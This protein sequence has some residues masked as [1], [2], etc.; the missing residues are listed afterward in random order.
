MNPLRKLAS[1]T[2]IYGFSSVVGRFL[3]YLLVPLFTYYFAPEEYGVIAELYAYMGFLTVTL[4]LGLETGYFRFSSDNKWDTKIVYSTTLRTIIG[5]N[6]LFLFLVFIFLT[7]LATNLRYQQ[8][9]QFLAWTAV[10]LAADSVGAIA[11]A[12][13]RAEHQ[14]MRFAGIKLLEIAVNIGFNLFFI[15]YCKAKYTADPTSWAGSLWYPEV[16]VGYVLIANLIA[17]IA[18][19][20]LL[21]TE[22]KG[23]T[24]GFNISLLNRIL[25]Y[26]LPMVIIGFAGIINEMLDRVVL[27][28]LLPYDSTQNMAQLGIYSAC[29]KLSILMSLFIQ[30]FRYAGE[31][32]FFAYAQQANAKQIY[33]AVLRY[34]VIA[35]VFIFLVVSLYID[36]F[37]YFVGAPYRVGIQVTPILLFANLFLGIYVNLSIWYKLS[38]HTLIGAAVSILGAVITLVLLLW[39]VPIFGYIGAAWATLVCY[40]TMAVISYILGNYYY[41]VP[42]D[43][44]RIITYLILGISIYCIHIIVINHTDI[45]SILV[46]TIEIVAF[47][48][49]A[50]W[51]DGRKLKIA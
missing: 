24:N 38:D 45:S 7:P 3:N 14:A 49:I 15:G 43:I 20:V 33:A 50:L 5:I 30:A 23:I 17:S 11:F 39:W 4:M 8:H 16:G 19:L 12:R 47:L 2:A 21:S 32:F 37:K 48:S 46:A 35:C 44:K 42:Y 18:K 6:S 9:P 29:Y 51:L 31:P 27:K 34:F 28:Y 26:S 13:L 41:P 1:Q 36:I 40:A 22:L 10:I 25:R